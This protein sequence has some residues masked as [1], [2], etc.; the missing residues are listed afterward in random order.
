[1]DVEKA[2]DRN[3]GYVREVQ[4]ER[5]L[6]LTVSFWLAAIALLIAGWLVVLALQQT[7]LH[8]LDVVRPLP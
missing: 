5:W 7:G 1:V 8:I 3:R 6:S 2:Q 4:A